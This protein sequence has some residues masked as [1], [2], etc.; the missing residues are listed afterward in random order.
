M[1][2]PIEATLSPFHQELLNQLKATNIQELIDFYSI[3]ATSNDDRDRKKKGW[4]L[5]SEALES[6]RFAQFL[7]K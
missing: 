6:F 4:L 5:I 3:P 1:N 2:E 7:I